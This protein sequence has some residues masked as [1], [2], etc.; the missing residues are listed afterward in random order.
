MSCRQMVRLSYPVLVCLGFCLA[1]YK[2]LCAAW[3]MGEES[4]VPNAI[5]ASSWAFGD[6]GASSPWT[7][8]IPDQ[9]TLFNQ[10]ASRC[11]TL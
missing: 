2:V 9:L 11:W 4:K 6:W 5:R 3:G 7:P 1:L 8:P 10:D